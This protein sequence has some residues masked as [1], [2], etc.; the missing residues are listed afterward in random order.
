MFL[1]EYRK[2][3]RKANIEFNMKGITPGID[4]YRKDNTVLFSLINDLPLRIRILNEIELE[5]PN[6]ISTFKEPL[7]TGSRIYDSYYS[8][9]KAGI[10]TLDE[11]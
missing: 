2:K 11:T 3:C 4:Y 1:N 8:I 6:W 9:A 5:H 7:S 10:S